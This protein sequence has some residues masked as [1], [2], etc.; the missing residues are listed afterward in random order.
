MIFDHCRK[1]AHQ[2]AE[3]AAAKLGSFGKKCKIWQL[4]AKDIS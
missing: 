1:I 4:A 2:P 3:L